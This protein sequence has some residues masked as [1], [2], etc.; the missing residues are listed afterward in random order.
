[1]RKPPPAAQID[2]WR[3]THT[4]EAVWNIAI[5][6]TR[7]RPHHRLQARRELRHFLRQRYMDHGRR[8]KGNRANRRAKALY[9]DPGLLFWPDYCLR[10]KHSTK[11]KQ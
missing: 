5:G 9:N 11:V 3:A 10:D 6:T 8:G 4:L 2:P 1:M 7:G